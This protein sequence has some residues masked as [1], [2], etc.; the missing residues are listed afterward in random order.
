MRKLVGG[1]VEALSDHEI[2]TRA[3]RLASVQ[4]VPSKLLSKALDE[5]HHAVIQRFNKAATESDV[6]ALWREALRQGQIEGAYWAV[7]THPLSGEAFFNKAFGDVHMLSHLVGCTNRADIRRLVQLESDISALKGQLEN[8][9]GAM[10]VGFSRRDREIQEVRKALAQTLQKGALSITPDEQVS[11]LRGALSQLQQQLDAAKDR[12]ARLETDRC[13][14]KEEK[15]LTRSQLQEA[16]ELNA[17]LEKDIRAVESCIDGSSPSTRSSTF[18]GKTFLYVG[19][20]G[21]SVDR[22]RSLAEMMGATLLH[23]DGG[24]AQNL[25]LLPGLVRRADYVFFPVDFVSHQAVYAVK[26]YCELSRTPFVPL[27]RS[28]T[29]SF[30]RTITE[31]PRPQGS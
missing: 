7:A 3:V 8:A 1:L 4:G 14:V 19:G 29:A 10:R 21:G 25:S 22:L 30:L 31:L 16:Q 26:K 20:K 9:H 6:A 5:K 23:H 17:E 2:H 24:Q 12:I 27:R 13:A 11:V 28:G 18:S 15:R